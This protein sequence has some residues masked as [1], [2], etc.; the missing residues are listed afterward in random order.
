[1]GLLDLKLILIICLSII[2]Y[3]LYKEILSIRYRLNLI[4]K[5]VSSI[6]SIPLIKDNVK[7]E[8]NNAL[9][10]TSSDSN[11]DTDNVSASE[12]ETPG[13][14]LN[15]FTNM[16]N[17][18]NITNNLSE[19][20]NINKTDNC[21]INKN[22]NCCNINKNDEKCN[23]NK[24]DNCCNYNVLDSNKK[25]NKIVYS[26]SLET[27]QPILEKSVDDKLVKIINI[28]Y[29]ET[30]ELND[31]L[32]D[33]QTNE[34]IDEQTNEQTN[35]QINEQMNEQTNEQINE[36]MNEQTNKQINTESS[37]ENISHLEVFSNDTEN[38]KV[39]ESNTSSSN[40]SSSNNSNK[41]S[42]DNSN[43]SNKSSSNN[44]NKSS[45]D[46][47]NNSNKSS[48]NNSN[49]SSSNN[50][51]KLSP[52]NS[53][54]SINKID[55]SESNTLVS[56]SNTIMTESNNNKSLTRLKLPELQDRALELKIP[57][58]VNGKKKTRVELIN[59]I[60]NHN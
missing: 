38:K 29:Q 52:N 48:S 7:H 25:I 19:K 42:S 16:F 22:D 34:Q 26:S 3:F 17:K 37:E 5:Q 20:C 8:I 41:S 4:T 58:S 54:K 35:E 30:N 45:S 59:E 44:S 39:S 24:N 28:E 57:L 55:V 11:N 36:Q 12:K 43:N 40:K 51:N 15:M 33:E 27:L 21:N 32:I 56:D 2:V 23:I 14:L 60:K 9:I 13:N 53:N 6:S 50:S 31:E 46:N 49:K 18:K 47:S 1:M 10:T